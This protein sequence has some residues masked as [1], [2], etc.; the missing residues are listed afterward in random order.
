MKISVE[1]DRLILRVLDD[2]SC[3]M[4]LHFLSKGKDIFEKYEMARPPLYYTPMYQKNVLSQE[5]SATLGNRYVRYYVFLK[6]KPDEVLCFHL[7]DTDDCYVTVNLTDDFPDHV[8]VSSCFPAKTL[9]M[10]E[11]IVR[12]LQKVFDRCNEEYKDK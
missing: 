7:D 4:V 12:Q 6:E 5:Y 11:S 1:T 9:R 10:D 8:Y 3:D 2:S